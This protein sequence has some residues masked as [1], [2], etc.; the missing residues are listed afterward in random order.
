MELDW[1]DYS[2]EKGFYIYD[3]ITRITEYIK[4]DISPIHIKYYYSKIKNS[5]LTDIIEKEVK[6]NYIKIIIDQAF[7]YDHVLKIMTY[8]NS[9]NP[10][11]TCE[12]D[13][14]FNILDK[15]QNINF[16]DID[17]SEIKMTKFDYIKTYISKM[18]EGI[19]ENISKD[20][21]INKAEKYFNLAESEIIEGE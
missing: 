14:M 21:L 13:F 3:T 17:N 4:N 6:K 19:F 10:I 5:Y 16:L 20:T 8:V 15:T 1:G 2:N 11:K 7:N 18:E 9:F 12:I